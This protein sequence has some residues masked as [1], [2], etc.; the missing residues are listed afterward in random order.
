MFVADF[1]V[2]QVEKLELIDAVLNLCSYRHPENIVLPK[3]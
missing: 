2:L 1:P 3:G